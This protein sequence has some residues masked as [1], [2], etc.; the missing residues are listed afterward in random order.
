MTAT[1]TSLPCDA[2]PDLEVA[3]TPGWAHQID[4]SMFVSEDTM[5]EIERRRDHGSGA[6]Y[7]A[8]ALSER[9]H[10]PGITLLFPDDQ[11]LALIFA[12]KAVFDDQRAGA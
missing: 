12:I 2:D 8:I 6:E 9:L 7:T 3:A 11:L 1:I 10:G 4:I 5:F